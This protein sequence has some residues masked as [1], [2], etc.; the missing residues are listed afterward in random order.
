MHSLNKV[1]VQFTVILKSSFKYLIFIRELHR[2]NC[3][4][5]IIVFLLKCVR[6]NKF[7]FY[8]LD[9]LIMKLIIQLIFF[10]GCINCESNR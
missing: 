10:N 2:R 4:R 1:R 7:L 3:E 9:L 6:Q 8:D 5:G